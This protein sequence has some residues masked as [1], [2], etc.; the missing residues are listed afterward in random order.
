MCSSDLEVIGDV[1]KNKSEDV[2]ITEKQI[3]N[4]IKIN[5]NLGEAVEELGGTL[6]EMIEIEDTDCIFDDL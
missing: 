5:P 4:K 6:L 3:N 2:K 1:K